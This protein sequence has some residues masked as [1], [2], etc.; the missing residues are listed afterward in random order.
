MSMT[1][2]VQGRVCQI[3]RTREATLN[4]NLHRVAIGEVVNCIIRFREAGG[5]RKVV[6]QQFP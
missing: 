6:T 4:D 1:E 3:K 5:W 2:W